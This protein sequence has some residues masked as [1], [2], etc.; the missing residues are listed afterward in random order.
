MKNPGRSRWQWVVRGAT[1]LALVLILVGEGRAEP[2]TFEKKGARPT[3][4]HL[5]RFKVSLSPADVFQDRNKPD[6]PVTVV[7]PGEIIT[8]TIT[9][10]PKEGYHTYPLTYGTKYQ[11]PDRLSSLVYVENPAIKPIYP[12]HENSQSEFKTYP[13]LKEVLLEYSRPF[14]WTQDLLISPKAKLG[15]TTNLSCSIKVVVCSEGEGGT[16]TPG[17]H[18]F[19]IPLRID[20]PLPPEASRAT[21]ILGLLAGLNPLL[22]LVEMQPGTP[23]ALIPPPPPDQI[24]PDRF[25]PI[26]PREV[27]IPPELANAAPAP[28]KAPARPDGADQAIPV[29]AGSPDLAQL[30]LVWQIFWVIGAALAMLITPCVFP[31]I[32][33]TVSFF[34]KQA[35]NRHGSPL[36]LALVYA[37]TVVA[38]LTTAVLLLGSLILNLANNPWLN[39][40]FGT[41][42]L[43]FALSLFGMFE[44]ELPQFLSNFTVSREGQ[45]LV[46]AF[47][48]ALTFTITSF[49]CTGPFLGVVLAPVAASQFGYPTLILLSLI[50]AVT[51]ASPFFL[52]ALF[53]SLLKSLPKSGSWLNSVKVVMGFIEV[54]AAFKFLS[55]AD[56]ALFP[57]NPRLF[58]YDTVLCSWIALSAA[59]GLYLLGVYRL[60]HDT[61]LEHIGVVRLLL[62]MFF[63]GLALH[64]TPNLWHANPSGSGFIGENLSAMLPAPSR[65]VTSEKGP[66]AGELSWYPSYEDAW[67]QAVETDKL[68][69]I[70]FTGVNC[71]NCRLNENNVFR[72]PEIK[73]ELAKYVRVQLYND[74]V[75]SPPGLT[76]RNPKNSPNGTWT[77]KR[78]PST[79]SAHPFMSFSGQIRKPWQ[80]TASFRELC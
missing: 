51:F 20:H 42:L 63:L 32:P 7:Q 28:D 18:E 64:L 47:F 8:L 62:A 80:R 52:L 40:G 70:D 77:G 69:F 36:L 76:R 48:M 78:T 75:Q 5:I 79:M 22:A 34:L 13:S 6:V 65:A 54:A 3:N 14:T 21:S 72:R 43:F 17:T 26:P 19:E 71:Q 29:V 50:Y 11:V 25:K 37:G 23:A 49:T 15:T 56:A 33:V 73:K 59:C 44:L 9:G 60:P 38:V 1:L 10:I 31:M 24:P 74:F 66:E 55:M 53:P 46:G 27:A 4:A 2:Q 16:C 57:G 45:G 30:S 67:K 58:T 35:E 68:L 12:I 39:L 41:L 61:P